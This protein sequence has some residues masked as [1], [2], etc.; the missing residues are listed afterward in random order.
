MRKLKIH[1][2]NALFI[3]LVFFTSCQVNQP[4][5]TVQPTLDITPSASAPVNAEAS[6]SPPSPSISNKVQTGCT[7]VSPRPTP[8]ATQQ[9]LFTPINQS[10]WIKGADKGTVQILEYGDF[11]C[12]N[13]AMLAPILGQLIE[14]YPDDVSIVYRHYPIITI[15][16]KAA[17]AAQASE[18]AG[19]QGYF[20]EMHDILFNR[21]SE[22]ETLSVD[23]FEAWLLEIGDEISMDPQKFSLDL[24]DNKIAQKITEAWENNLNIGIPYTPFLLFNN[25][26]WPDALPLN[27][28]SLIEITEMS[29]L[30]RKQYT[31][32]PPLTINITSNY[33]A[34]IH[35]EYG[36]IHIELFADLAPL[37]VNNF[38]F[39]AQNGWYDEV[40][41]HRVIPGFVAQAG[42]PSGT[43]YGSPGYAFINEQ[44]N[45]TF[46]QPGL[47]AMANSG[48]DTNGSQFFITL[49]SAP[50]LNGKYTIFGKVT[51]GMDIV[52]KLTPR[53]P[54]QQT[55]LQPGD[56]ILSVDILEN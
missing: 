6:P 36:A 42:D 26:I 2:L 23:E 25:Q 37:A 4:E 53:D 1:T 41:F 51:S 49:G 56:K 46:N 9:S 55:I 35:T 22:W 32:C 33:E 45:L 34:I 7:V 12:P 52:E 13:C 11:Q 38:I 28:L 27:L 15:H 24:H 5:A 19:I 50:N 31:F 16:D 54:E 39:L 44:S 30:E 17:L 14:K 47:V 48:I 8:G 43:G 10:D 40:T 21:Q 29:L 3:S 20:W 18:A